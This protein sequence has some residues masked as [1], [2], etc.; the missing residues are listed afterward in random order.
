MQSDGALVNNIKIFNPNLSQFIDGFMD[1]RLVKSIERHTKPIYEWVDG[2]LSSFNH[3]YP[4]E[5]LSEFEILVRNIT[6]RDF[7]IPRLQLGGSKHSVAELS[8]QQLD[9]LFDYYKD[10]YAL[11]SDFYTVDTIWADWKKSAT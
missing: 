2:D 9:F 8:K 5:K 11:L 3:I 4:L 1:Y 10:D 7:N 6:N